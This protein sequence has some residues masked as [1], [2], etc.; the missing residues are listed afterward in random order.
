MAGNFTGTTGDFGVGRYTSLGGE[1]WLQGY[2]RATLGDSARAIA[3][4]SDGN[5][6]VAGTTSMLNFT[7]SY[8]YNTQPLVF[9]VDADGNALWSDRI[10]AHGEASGVAVAVNGDVYVTGFADAGEI[11]DNDPPIMMWLRRYVP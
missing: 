2:D 1:T 5:L 3:V 10:A 11:D 8:W 9:G 4:G 7:G 6:A